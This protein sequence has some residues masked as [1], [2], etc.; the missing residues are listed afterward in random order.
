MHL[1]LKIAPVLVLVGFMGSGKSTAGRLLAERLGWSFLDLD[2]EI[3]RRAGKAVTQIFEQ[4]GESRFRQLEHEALVEQLQLSRNGRPRVL[5]VG[6]GAFVEARNQQ[7]LEMGGISI[8]L[9]CP[10]ETLWERVSRESHRPLAQRREDFERLYR[11]RL[12]HYQRADFTLPAGA[13]EP[14]EVVEAILKL[15]LF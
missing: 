5:A 1:K 10:V 11:E 12:P 2:E 3:E 9:D 6:G 8:W 14:L 15:P 7:Q 13:A 4:E